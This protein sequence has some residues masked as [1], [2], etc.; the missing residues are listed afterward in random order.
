VIRGRYHLEAP[1]E[2]A[3]SIWL[4]TENWPLWMPGVSAV[5]TLRSEE[6]Y[7]LLEVT[8]TFFG[9]TFVQDL[10]CRELGARVS[11]RQ[12]RGWFSKF[13]VDWTFE[14]HPRR[15]GT[16]LSVE[17]DFGMGRLALLSPKLFV[18]VWM[19]GH[20]EKTVERARSRLL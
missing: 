7:R 15:G 9:H 12:H 5:S 14:A 6:G 8:Q 1:V 2:D 3:R 13:E 17:L 19:R 20:L 4:E 11:H 16:L 10:E 18:N